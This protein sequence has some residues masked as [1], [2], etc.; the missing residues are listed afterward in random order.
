MSTELGRLKRRAEFLYAARRGRRFA[1]PGLVLQAVRALD[2]D[3]QSTGANI[4][5]TASKK[6]GNAVAR[7]R[8]KRRLRGL[9]QDIMP[10]AAKSGHNYVLIA[11]A[12]TLNRSYQDLQSDLQ[13]AL[14]RVHQKKRNKPRPRQGPSSPESDRK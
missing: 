12:G 10:Q 13:T 1:T 9:V 3:D 11:R 6:V 8:A 2:A 7:N 4:G 14:T 5:F